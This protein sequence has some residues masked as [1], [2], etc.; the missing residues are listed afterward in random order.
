MNKDSVKIFAPAS[1]SNVGPG[2]DILGFALE[3][4]G[5]TIT[6]SKRNGQAYLIDA[7]GADIPQ[8]P[9]KNVATVALSS[10]CKEVGYDGGFLIRIEKSFT[11]GSGLGSSASSAVGA[12]FAANELLNTGMTKEELVPF[13]FDGEMLASGHRH[14]DN[15]APC[16]LGGFV[17]VKS[18][19]PF[20]G[21]QISYPKALK[22]LILFP[23]VLVKTVEARGLLPREVPMAQAIEQAAN[24]A[25]LINGLTTANYQ[26]IR[27][28]MKDQ[29]AQPYRKKLIP[30]YDDVETVC[31][32]NEAIGFNISG[33]G[34]AMFAFFKADQNL[35]PLKKW[36]KDF[37][38]AKGIACRFYES[39]INGRG[40]ERI[41]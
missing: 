29:L 30:G 16:M 32:E 24:M 12:V 35:E 1:V 9:E 22:V 23:D 21:F 6:L 26:M 17:A 3:G 8:D 33:S 37:Y 14:G 4:I 10:F 15:V 25:G 40:V 39:A 36:V 19:D 38:E 5:D 18:C 13:A 11:P 27:K 41:Q 7:V 34:P 2:F 20:D 31:L 28:Y